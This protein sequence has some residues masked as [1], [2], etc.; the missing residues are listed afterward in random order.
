MS[1]ASLDKRPRDVAAMFDG[2]ARRYDLTNTVLSGGRDRGWRKATVAALA[3]RPRDTVLDL[4]A[5]T[6]ISTVQLRSCGATAVACDFSLGMLKS[7]KA[8][9]RDVPMVAGDA[10]ALPFADRS[11]D[12]ATI[13]FGLRNVADVDA[14]LR[15]LARVTKPGGRLVVCEFSRPTW[16]PW[17][18]VYT[19][20]LMRAL[21]AVARRV[22][23][24]P[25]RVRLPRRVDPGLAGPAQAGPAHRG[26]RLAG[27]AVAR[28][29]RRHRRAA[30][31]R[32]AGPVGPGDGLRGG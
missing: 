2:V 24:N 26:R 30:P 28:P 4:A 27:R 14:A 13:A 31:G 17:R 18:T 8:H 19:E 5:G 15:E 22:S 20:Y 25:R 23:S 3:L 29:D 32:T 10:L 11:F 16:A 1:R 6:A 7:G 21:P 9:G 12:A